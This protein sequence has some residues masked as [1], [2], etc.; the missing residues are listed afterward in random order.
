M[1]FDLQ[2]DIEINGKLYPI[3]NKGD[4]R[5]ILDVISAL[6]DEDLSD[7]EKIQCA[8]FIFFENWTEIGD[9]QAAAKE[10]FAFIAYTEGDTKGDAPRLM[11]WEHDFKIIAPSI[12]RVLGS[13]VRALGYLHWWSFVGAYFEIGEST[14]STVVSIRKKLSKGEKLEKWEREFMREHSKMVVLPTKLTAEEREWLDS[15]W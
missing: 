11:D 1:N 8:L 4:Y 6:N 12:S 10:M 14:F 15:E 9:F 7:Q 13:E 2:T 3:R 5:V